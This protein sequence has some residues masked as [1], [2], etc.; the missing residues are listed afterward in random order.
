[1]KTLQVVFFKTLTVISGFPTVEFP[2]YV[3]QFGS[4]TCEINEQKLI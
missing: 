2:L 3:K 4:V 1:M